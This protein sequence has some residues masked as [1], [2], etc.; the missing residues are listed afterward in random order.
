MRSQSPRATRFLYLDSGQHVLLFAG[1][2][3]IQVA[4]NALL[5]DNKIGFHPGH[6]LFQFPSF[7]REFGRLALKLL[8][9]FLVFHPF[10]GFLRHTSRARQQ[11][12]G[13]DVHIEQLHPLIRQGE[14]ANL[15]GVGYASSL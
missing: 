11:A 8:L 1:L 14:L 12:C 3:L 13:S 5:F 7:G 9:A 4:L 6:L 2:H 15:V 10:S